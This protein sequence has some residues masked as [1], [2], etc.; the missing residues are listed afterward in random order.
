MVGL[1]RP[2]PPPGRRP[3]ARAGAR[4][5]PLADQ[6]IVTANAQ[7]A[8]S[9]GEVLVGIRPE[10]FRPVDT[11]PIFTGEVEI[12]EALGEVTLLYFRPQGDAAA[13]DRLESLIRAMGA[14]GDVN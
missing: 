9:N 7:N 10:D 11:A 6:Q 1:A 12:T 3:R 4:V 14:R 13:L 2:A 5:Q 8:Q